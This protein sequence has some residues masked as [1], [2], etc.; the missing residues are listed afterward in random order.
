[1]NRWDEKEYYVI[2]DADEPSMNAIALLLY[3]T[4]E[5]GEHIL[6]ER[7]EGIIDVEIEDEIHYKAT[8]DDI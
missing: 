5:E 1:M 4:Q 3:P 6:E 2:N 8:L 7:K